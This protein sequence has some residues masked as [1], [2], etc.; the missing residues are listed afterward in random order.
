MTTKLP[1]LFIIFN[2]RKTASLTH[3]ASVEIRVTYDYKQ[4]Y[5]STGVML[6]ANQWKNGKIINCPDILQISKILNVQVTNIRQILMEMLQEGAIDIFAIPERLKQQQM[7][8]STF[9]D[10][11]K[12]RA[13]VRKYGKRKDTQDRYDRF[14]RLFSE[15]GRIKYFTD[16]T[17]ANIIAYDE[18]L[19]N[20]GIQT[21]SKW[22]NYHRFLSG[23]ISD[24]IADGLL[25]RNPYNWLNIEKDKQSHGLDKCLTL[26]EFYKL[27][28]TKMPTESLERVKDLFVFQTYTCLRYSDL[29]RFDSKNIVMVEGRKVY[30]CL[31]QKTSKYAT[32]PLLTSTI[33]I[34]EKYN[35][36]LPTIS[37]VK[38]NLYLKTIAQAAGLDKSLSTHWARHTGATI[39][40]NEGVDMKV[41]TK[42]CG[43]SSTRITEQVYAKLLDETVV[44]AVAELNI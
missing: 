15:W 35:N 36:S 26:K 11:C 24:A 1:Q 7:K 34:L 9:I 33:D 3:K 20:K 38:Y 18:Y 5:I 12:Q 43:H 44:D 39:L 31:Q 17:E 30:K 14:I 27:K 32:I 28:A 21:Y 37:N 16:I 42:I 29:R 10:F 25:T 23:F 4:K 8:A 40:L 19:I 2:R 6:Y 22:N 13:T 41:V